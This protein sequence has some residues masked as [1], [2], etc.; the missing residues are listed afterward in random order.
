MTVD[1]FIS[2]SVDQDLQ[3][4]V[5]ETI[6]TFQK[7]DSYFAAIM[8]QVQTLAFGNTESQADYKTFLS[9]PISTTGVQLPSI[10]S[11]NTNY[12][13]ELEKK[14]QGE[15]SMH[16]SMRFDRQSRSNVHL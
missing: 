11:V 14:A 9:S 16:S 4:G 7:L 6:Q 10:L 2:P 13:L 5:K 8:Y 1:Q 15:S 12:L 3:N